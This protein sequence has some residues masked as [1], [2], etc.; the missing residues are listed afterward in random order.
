[1]NFQKKPTARTLAIREP[2]RLWSEAFSEFYMQQTQNLHET[3]RQLSSTSKF[4]SGILLC[5]F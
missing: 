1:M 3:T 4:Y 5:F 2:L